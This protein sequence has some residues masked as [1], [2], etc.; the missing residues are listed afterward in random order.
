MPR[1]DEYTYETDLPFLL[2]TDIVRTPVFYTKLANWHDDIEL[3]Y[4]K[5]G[6][7]LLFL[8]GEKI[9]FHQG[10]FIFIPSNSIH[11]L[12]PSNK[13]TYSCLLIKKSFCQTLDFNQNISC[14]FNNKELT[15]LF[16]QLEAL[17]STPNAPFVKMKKYHNLLNQLII[18]DE[19]HC[20]VEN[21][22]INTSTTQQK[23][24]EVIIYIREHFSEKIT[25][26]KISKYVAMSKFDLSRKFK[27]TTNL[28]II[29]FVNYYRCKIAASKIQNGIS[30]S[31]AAFSCGFENMSYFTKTFKKYFHCLPS[32]QKQSKQ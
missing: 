7:G 16:L 3:E 29:E 25:L 15:T 23:I 17:E 6:E 18:L 32:Q 27:K 1:F 14:Q 13:V 31:E 22:R 24:Q 30:V 9:F 5:E 2:K 26:D 28:T 11:H 10:D 4:I 19:R 20:S 12:I 21:N 8:D